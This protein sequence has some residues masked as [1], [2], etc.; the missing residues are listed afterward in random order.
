MIF[1]LCLLLVCAFVITSTYFGQ[2]AQQPSRPLLAPVKQ[3]GGTSRGVTTTDSKTCK[4]QGMRLCGTQCCEPFNFVAFDMLDTEWR[5]ASSWV[6]VVENSYLESYGEA[7]PVN[8]E[9]VAFGDTGLGV[10]VKKSS[11]TEYTLLPIT[12]DIKGASTTAPAQLQKVK[13]QVS[14]AAAEL[15][16]NSALFITA[17]PIHQITAGSLWKSTK[18]VLRSGSTILLSV[19]DTYLG[20]NGDQAIVTREP[21]LWIVSN[22]KE[23]PGYPIRTSDVVFL[24]AADGAGRLYVRGNSLALAPAP[25]HTSD[26]YWKLTDLTRHVLAEGA[27]LSL[28]TTTGLSVTIDANNKLTLSDDA[29]VSKKTLKLHINTTQENLDRCSRY[30]SEIRR[31]RNLGVSFAH[32]TDLYNKECYSI[33][34]G[35]FDETVKQNEADMVAKLAAL[36]KEKTAYES[37]VGQRSTTRQ[38]IQLLQTEIQELQKALNGLRCQPYKVCVPEV[39]PPNVAM[40]DTQGSVVNHPDISKYV[41]T[42]RVAQ[43][44]T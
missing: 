11:P 30:V 21:C 16:S 31:F 13:C 32:L 34:Q 10:A 44:L 8:A 38:R 4:S 39:S 41:K 14:I 29:D 12:T 25:N 2:F 23:K 18:N 1:L 37:L 17:V 7:V 9:L 20:H 28:Q 26:F 6:L 15:Q 27:Q 5:Q 22:I 43:C 36:D 33:P 3:H 19:G 35:V 24:A 40:A 42:S